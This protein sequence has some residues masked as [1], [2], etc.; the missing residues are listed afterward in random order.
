MSTESNSIRTDRQRVTEIRDCF[1]TVSVSQP[2][3]AFQNEKVNSITQSRANEVIF[4]R[5]RS[6]RRIAKRISL[7]RIV[8]YTSNIELPK[9]SDNNKDVNQV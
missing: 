4:I 6:S 9:I 2:S 7:S 5:A 8:R 1:L 3:I